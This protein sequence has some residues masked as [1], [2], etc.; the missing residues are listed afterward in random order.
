MHKGSSKGSHT[1]F[2][3]KERKRKE[4]QNLLAGVH[5]GSVSV[6]SSSFITDFGLCFLGLGLGLGLGCSCSSDNSCCFLFRY[7]CFI[8]S[9]LIFSSSFLIRSSSAFLLESKDIFNNQ[10]QWVFP[11]W[12]RN[13]KKKKKTFLLDS[14]A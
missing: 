12:I 5:F 10:I 7:S 3:H 8:S 1:C 6:E 4:K 11:W 2:K 9:R 14:A 13:Q